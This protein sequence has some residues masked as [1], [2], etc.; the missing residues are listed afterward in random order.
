MFITTLLLCKS[1][2]VCEQGGAERVCG[3]AELWPPA[4]GPAV[5]GCPAGAG[6]GAPD[7][8]GDAVPT[9]PEEVGE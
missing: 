1:L 4:A 7:A 5:G 8:A 3:A 9:E 6:E 2:Q